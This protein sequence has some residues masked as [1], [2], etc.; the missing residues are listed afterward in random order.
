MQDCQFL[1]AVVGDLLCLQKNLSH[2]Y[3]FCKLRNLLSPPVSTSCTS[4][5]AVG[6]VIRCPPRSLKIIFGAGFHPFDPFPPLSYSPIP[7]SGFSVGPSVS[8]CL[9]AGTSAPSCLQ[10]T[11]FT[12]L[13][14]VI[15]LLSEQISSP[16]I[17]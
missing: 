5:T 17:L 13:H 7:T 15:D 8:V 3:V 16:C 1:F 2:L 6:A 10:P 12:L 4:H 11:I 14:M 9:K